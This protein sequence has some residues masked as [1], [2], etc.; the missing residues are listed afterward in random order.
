MPL[1]P[2]DC[3]VVDGCIWASATAVGI[4]IVGSLGVPRRA[5]L[6]GLLLIRILPNGI[7]DSLAFR[8]AASFEVGRVN[9][10]GEISPPAP[11]SA[12]A[13]SVFLRVRKVFEAM[14]V[15]LSISKVACW[16]VGLRK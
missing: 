12:A 13:V 7:G 1:P 8:G 3:W 16:S 15:L 6:F 14:V 2:T 9:P 4:V 11:P 5:L 10:V